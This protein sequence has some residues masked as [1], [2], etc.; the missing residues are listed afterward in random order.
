MLF[1]KS[2]EVLA[3]QSSNIQ[4][5]H[6]HYCHADQA[7][8]GLKDNEGE[9]TD[10]KN[11][12]N[13]TGWHADSKLCKVSWSTY[14]S[15]SFITKWYCS[16]FVNNVSQYWLKKKRTQTTAATVQEILTLKKRGNGFFFSLIITK[17]LIPLDTCEGRSMF[18]FLFSHLKQKDPP[19]RHLPRLLQCFKYVLKMKLHVPLMYKNCLD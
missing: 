8:W 14:Y 7:K 6:H 16:V 10:I 9:I 3:D 13:V 1:Q 4:E 18:S 15:L 19:L 11:A 12:R 17:S 5:R 2:G